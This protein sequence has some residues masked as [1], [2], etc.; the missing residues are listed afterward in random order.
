M[1][2]CAEPPRPGAYCIKY[3]QQVPHHIVTYYDPSTDACTARSALPKHP[4]DIAN[5]DNA[6]LQPQ[7]PVIHPWQII[8]KEV[9]T[10]RRQKP[11]PPPRI[12]HART[13]PLVAIDDKI[14]N[15]VQV[16]P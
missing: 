6:S 12:I 4:K 5:R 10:V 13:Q 2:D 14:S 7:I 3:R 11:T 15:G 8:E 9:I 1:V 16:R